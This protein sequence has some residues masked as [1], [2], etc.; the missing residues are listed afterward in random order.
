LKIIKKN[1]ADMKKEDLSK[2]SIEELIKEEKKSKPNLIVMLIVIIAMIIM[3]VL[4]TIKS[5]FGI[6]T[7]LP[8]IFLPIALNHWSKNKLIRDEIKSRDN[9]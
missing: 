7:F 3:A 2:L 5:G 6:F 8:I 9:K 4:N 1:N